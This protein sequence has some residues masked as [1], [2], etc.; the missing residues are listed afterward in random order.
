MAHIRSSEA[1][2][3]FDYMFL[4]FSSQNEIKGPSV[5]EARG[6]S[7]GSVVGGMFSYTTII[8]VSQQMEKSFYFFVNPCF[9]SLN[10]INISTISIIAIS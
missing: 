10:Y 1:S 3:R 5:T 8:L 4:D 2:V 9:L 7:S 6:G